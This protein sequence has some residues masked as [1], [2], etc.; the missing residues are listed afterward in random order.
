M[1]AIRSRSG[2]PSLKRVIATPGQIVSCP[3]AGDGR[4]RAVEVNG[5]A[6]RETYVK[7]ST[8]PFAAVTVPPRTVFV[9]GDNRPFSADS[10]MTGPV[11]VSQIEGIAV[12]VE[13]DSDGH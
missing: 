10:R 12:S 9:L 7:G 6:L 13:T 1:V 2:G 3:D 11:P 4:C 5:V 8:H